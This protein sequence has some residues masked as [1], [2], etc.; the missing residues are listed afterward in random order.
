MAWLS[1][2]KTKTMVALEF[3]W[4]LP[5][6]HLSFHSKSPWNPS[7]F[8]SSS[9]SPSSI[10]SS[11]R[12]STTSVG[13]GNRHISA[14]LGRA[15]RPRFALSEPQ[16]QQ[17]EEDEDEEEEEVVTSDNGGGNSTIIVSSCLIGLLTGI[18]IV[19]FNIG[20]KSKTLISLPFLLL[21]EFTLTL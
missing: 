3:A 17:E 9:S 12:N 8:S 19:L 21:S 18:G 1:Q 11:S 16:Q 6:T 7:F 5:K 2:T 10:S 13:L 14:K 4:R 15:L 20:V